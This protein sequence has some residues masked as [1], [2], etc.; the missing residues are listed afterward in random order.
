MLHCSGYAQPFAHPDTLR[1]GVIFSVISLWAKCRHTAMCWLVPTL[2]G[3]S[4]AV[5]SPRP[6]SSYGSKAACQL[7]T[8]SDPNGV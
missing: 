6:T 8:I 4:R 7:S 3:I 5:Y 1:F 2:N